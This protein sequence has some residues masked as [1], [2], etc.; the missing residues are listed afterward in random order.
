MA[1]DVVGRRI[2]VLIISFIT[3]VIGMVV[4]L[5]VRDFVREV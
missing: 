3:T 2:V 4:Y 1:N 5:G